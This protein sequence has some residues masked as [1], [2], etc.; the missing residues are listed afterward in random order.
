M[1]DITETS[2]TRTGIG[3][4]KGQF[5]KEKSQG[6]KKKFRKRENRSCDYCNGNGHTRETCFKLNGY[7]E[8]FTELK[9]KKG[10]GKGNI[11]ANAYEKAAE[12]EGKT[13]Q[14]I[15]KASVDWSSII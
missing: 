3:T 14:K 1:A 9:Q 11:A 8:W 7:L 6:K 4:V 5:Q 13:E 12:I 10:K 15:E 2:R